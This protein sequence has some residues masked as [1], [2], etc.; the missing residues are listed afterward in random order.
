MSSHLPI[1][2]HQA[3]QNDCASQEIDLQFCQ[4]PE[5][6][7]ELVNG[8]FL[9]GGTIEGSRWLLKEALLGWGLEAAIAFAPP[10]HWWEALRQ[11]HGLSYQSE[12]AWLEWAESLPL[13]TDYR[14]HP[15]PLLGSQ[16]T[17]EHRRVREHLRQLLGAA[18]S[19]ANLGHCLGPNYG[20]QLG[21]HML[22]PDVLLLTTEQLEQN[23][24]HDYYAET[25]AHLVIET[26][27]PER[28]VDEQ[29]RR[30]LYEQ[31]HISHYWTVDPIA[32]QFVF[33]QWTAEGY[34][35]GE[36]DQ[37]GCYRGVPNLSAS[38]E[39]FWL[40][41]EQHLSPYDQTLPAFTCIPQPRRWRLER[42]PGIE[43]SYGTEPFV[44]GVGLEPQPIS[45]EQFVSWCPETKLEGPP[46]P[47]LGGEK[48]TRNAIALLLMSLGLVE[49]VKLVAG[50]EWVR[51]L[52]SIAR[53]RQF[54]VQQRDVWWQRTREI[55]TQLKTVHGVGGVGII[56]SLVDPTPLHRWSEIHLILWDV[57]P[58][59][60][61]W[62]VYSSLPDDLP[63]EITE[64]VWALLGT[65]QEIATRMQVLEGEWSNCGPRP[66]ECMVF[67]YC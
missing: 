64:A 57:P 26:V 16:Y 3:L 31:A 19:R 6:R 2:P 39:L 45:I 27:M 62:Q 67:R 15:R 42:E 65:W 29:V 14:H 46:F 10:E 38:P 48:G 52:R 33:W 36:L 61:I 40:R 1:D 5:V 51:V 50:Y 49:T 54:E 8:Q 20:M 56:G 25:A 44:P 28:W 30:S 58:T 24:V 4:W 35:P 63:I 43:L 41:Y 7:F 9:V 22:T 59:F 53:Q 60:K 32:R 66:R 34:R 47:L 17:G 11:A 55:A 12:A 37:D 21:Q 13:S 18:V 23:V